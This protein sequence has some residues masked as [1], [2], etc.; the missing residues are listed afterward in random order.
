MPIPGFLSPKAVP[1]VQTS[2]AVASLGG[3]PAP[4]QGRIPITVERQQQDNWCWSAVGVAVERFYDATRTRTQC[5]LAGIAL[6]RSDCCTD[7]ADDPAKCDQPWYLD[8]VLTITGNLESMRPGTLGFPEI[9]AR[10][11]DGSPVGCRIGWYGGGGHFAV[12]KGWL[13]GPGGRR[14]IDV[15]DPIFLES[16]VAFDD[17]PIA[18]QSGGDWTHTYLT[19]P[20]AALGGAVLAAADTDFT[21]DPDTLGA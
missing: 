18:Y 14:Y 7:G 6:G 12:I 17:F 3:A 21:P 2:V 11:A 5:Q 13:V 4:A 9:Q 16:Q 20:A 15:S 19:V 1:L 8:R 10:V